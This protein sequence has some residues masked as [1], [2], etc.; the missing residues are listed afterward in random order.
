VA[1]TAARQRTS[2]AAPQ[3]AAEA[4][5]LQHIIDHAAHYLPS[6]G[7]LTVFV[8]HNTIHAFED[9]PFPLAVKLALQVYG[10]Q[11]YLSEDRYREELSRG[12]FRP[13]DLAAV[14]EDDLG[15]QADELGGLL[16]T[17]FHLRLAMLQHSLRT[18]PSA[19]LRWVIAETDALRK[20]RSDAAS[21]VR[22]RVIDSTRR[23]IMRDFRNVG[24]PSA[25]DPYSSEL[26]GIISDLLTSFGKSTIEEWT[27]ATW[28]SFYLQLLWRVCSS[29]VR[30]ARRVHN[31]PTE[32]ERHRDVL[33]EATGHDS[34]ELVHD[35]FIRFCAAFLD[36]GFAHWPLPDRDAGFYQSFI[37]LYSQPGGVMPS[38]LHGIRQEL[39]RLK[40]HRVTPLECIEESLDLLG[41][42]VEQREHFLMATLLALRGW[43]GM[44]WQMETNAEWTVHPAPRGSLTEFLAIRLLLDRYAVAFMAEE[45]LDYRGSLA[46]MREALSERHGSNSDDAEVQRAFSFFQLA[47]FL[48]LTPEQLYRQPPKTWVRLAE[49]VEAFS[50]LERRRVFHFAYE[51]RYRIQT[52]DAISLQAGR[53]KLGLTSKPASPPVFQLFCC[54]DDREESFRRHLE[55]I[56]PGCETFGYAGFYG[57]AMYYRGAAEAHPRPLCPV[58]IKPK[59][60][61]EE[62][63]VY[64]LA[65]AHRRRAFARRLVG[66]A[67]HEVH[68]GSLSLFG[69]A[70]TSIFGSLASLPM[71]ARILFPRTASQLRRLIGQVVQPPAVTQLLLE[72]QDPTPGPEP[73]H[74]G[75][76]VIEMG[77]IV[78][79]TLRDIGLTKN[80]ARLIVLCG[81]GSGSLNNPHESAYNCGA[82]SGGRGG[83]N[84]RAFSQMANDPR[85]RALLLDRGIDLPAETRFVGAYHNTCNDEVQYFDLDR[86]PITH[87]EDFEHAKRTIDEARRRNAHERCRRFE[88]VELSITPVAALAQVEQRSEDLSQARPEYNHATNAVTFVGRRSQTRGLYMDRRCFFASYD[89]TQDDENSTIL[90]RILAAVIPV[91]AGIS[92]EYYFSCVDVQGYGCGSKLPHNIT[93]LLGV[94]EGA[95]TDLRTG[96]SLQMIEIHEPMREIFVIETTPESMDRLVDASPVISQ[97]VRNEWVQLAVLS[98]KDGHIYVLTR[99][100]QWEQYTPESTDLPKAAASIDWYRGWRG[101]L[102]YALITGTHEDSNGLPRAVNAT[103]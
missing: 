103:L 21:E 10:C 9:R 27:E 36:Q 41:V 51:R 58:V 68:R 85:V 56:E 70:L 102:G 95:L 79:R 1:S 4:E 96:L 86:L 82:C 42:E 60:Y 15:D 97:L 54:I 46:D 80:F 62:H 89:P 91:C 23:W 69:G 29:G 43:A 26:R 22:K 83:P 37:D 12:R 25:S 30:N 76:T 16:G 34:D 31:P 3:R 18:A 101:N 73:G 90:G 39:G 6:Q 14:L 99:G 17:R 93:S 100:R 20:F 71:V 45:Q 38:W 98:P 48:G 66:S 88:S 84:A 72:R 33:L 47:Q 49:E 8:H 59:H 78:E 53:T 32:Q 28:E 63:P 94:M 92:L 65:E 74:I 24:A 57:V 50:E 2:V 61:V 40:E 87:R 19:E 44:I 77:E 55:E 52:L 35:V 81:H 75:Y 67:S 13:E 7:P 5:E 11:P 64:T